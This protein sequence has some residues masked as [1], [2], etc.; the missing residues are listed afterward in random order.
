[1]LFNIKEL[2]TFTSETRAL[3]DGS[4]VPTR[5]CQSSGLV[6]LKDRVRSA[7]LVLTGKADAVEW[8]IPVKAKKDYRLHGVY[9]GGNTHDMSPGFDINSLRIEK[10]GFTETPRVVPRQLHPSWTPISPDTS[11]AVGRFD[12]GYGP[13][14]CLVYDEQ[15]N[16]LTIKGVG[17]VTLSYE[18]N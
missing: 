4:M 18:V 5:P 1:M 11:S 10:F 12:T 6:G 15:K 8:S 17:S 14:I 3:V 2:I 7:W 13:G 16:Q 9:M